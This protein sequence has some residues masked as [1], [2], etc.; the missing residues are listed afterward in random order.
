MG[1]LYRVYRAASM[2]GKGLVDPN[3]YAS[4]VTRQ[5]GGIF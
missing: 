5:Y 4:E 2:V 3:V 1:T